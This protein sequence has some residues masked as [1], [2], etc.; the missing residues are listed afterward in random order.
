ML[1]MSRAIKRNPDEAWGALSD[2]RMA[3]KEIDEKYKIR[4]PETGE[5]VDGRLI[6]VQFS[7]SI[8]LFTISNQPQDLYAILFKA[9]LI[10]CSALQNC[11]PMRGGISHGEFFFNPQLNMFLGSPLINA[12]NIGEQCQWL[13]IVVDDA[14][15]QNKDCL[16]KHEGQSLLVKYAVPLNNGKLG[17]MNVVNWPVMFKPTVDLPLAVRQYYEPFERL[18]GPFESQEKKDQ[19]K[20]KTTVDFINDSLKHTF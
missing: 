15:F 8:I 12:H 17:N 2:L 7:D 4:Y 9:Y 11:V 18:F 14:V 3:E 1:G 19:I 13:G 5:I 10:F 16:P 6:K 20:Y